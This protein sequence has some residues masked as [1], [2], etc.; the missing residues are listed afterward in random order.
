MDFANSIVEEKIL[1]FF[2]EKPAKSSGKT[3]EDY[4]LFCGKC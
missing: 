2:S 1:Q 3:T 4:V